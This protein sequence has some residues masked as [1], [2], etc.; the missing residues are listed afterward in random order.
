MGIR[1]RHNFKAVAI[2]MDPDDAKQE[3]GRLA[4]AMD[5]CIRYKIISHPV[6]PKN[7]CPTDFSIIDLKKKLEDVK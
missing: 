4:S 2:W 5:N 1:I 3:P 7:H 6:D